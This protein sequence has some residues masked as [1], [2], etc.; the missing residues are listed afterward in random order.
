MRGTIEVTGEGSPLAGEEESK[1][2][3]YQQLGIDI[4]APHPAPAVPQEK[5]FAAA[6]KPLLAQVPPGYL[7]PDYYRAHSPARAWS[8]LKEEPLGAVLDDEQIWSIVAA[9]WQMNTNPSVLKD[10]RELYAENCAACHGEGGE[11]DGV[12]ATSLASGMGD[13]RPVDFTAA[14]TMLGASPALLQG[15]IIRGGMGTG[16]PYWGPIFTEEQTWSLVD[17]LLTFQFD[18]EMETKR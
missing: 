12:M 1:P 4:D 15:K 13:A 18:Y 9:I 16:M 14:E 17:Y 11:G 8:E 5:S 3:L 6:G 2:P 7:T 10:G